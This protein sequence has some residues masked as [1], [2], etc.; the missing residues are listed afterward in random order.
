MKD[1]YL[2]S[3]TFLQGLQVIDLGQAITEYQ[4]AIAAGDQFGEAVST[5][6]EG[7]ATDAIIN[8][9]SLPLAG[10]GMA[11]MFGLQADDFATSN[12]GSAAATQTLLAATGNAVPFVM[13]DPTL[14]GSAA[15]LYPASA[16][17]GSLSQTPLQMTSADG[18]T[19]YQF[20]MGRAVALG[21]ITATN[22]SGATTSQHI[23]VLVGSGRTGSPASLVPALAVVDV[24]GTYTPGA[25]VTC[26]P[27]AP[28]P[29]PNCPQM[30]GF[31][32]LPTTASNV[33]LN[34]NVALVATGANILLV[35]LAN[36]SQPI[37][38]GQIAG[39]FGNWLTTSSSGVIV[40]SSSSA[41]SGL[42]VSSF[43]IVPQLTASP[44]LLLD[45]IN[46]AT[47][48]DLKL[49]Y[50]LFGPLDDV[51]QATISITDDLG[52]NLYS[53]NVPVQPFG[54]IVW[55]AG[56][57]TPTPPPSLAKTLSEAAERQFGPGRAAQALAFGFSGASR[58]MCVGFFRLAT[59]PKKCFT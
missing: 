59:A 48:Q 9:I 28:T 10:G 15:V 8:T 11:T 19:A 51:A 16:S 39:S 26:S 27:T 29:S 46:G 18:N 36:P 50:A 17:D 3:A 7:F 35:N 31:L 5:A 20:V 32:Q 37:L 34:G 56:Q 40:G 42:Q 4:Q 21:T 33:T 14:S 44:Q 25:T 2:Y 13:A 47:A 38:A 58:F 41:P 6:G 49:N 43:D 57:M 53:A 24:S 45:D 30:I 54:Q 23:A 12:S 1:A 22:S 55:P 52:N